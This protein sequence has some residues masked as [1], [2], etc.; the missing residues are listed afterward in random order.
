MPPDASTQLS[1]ALA[2]ACDDPL[3]A[4]EPYGED[5]GIVRVLTTEHAI[6]VLLIGHQ[7][8]VITVL[9]LNYTG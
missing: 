5:D 4:T 7:T 2:S 9:Q 1:Y 3:G 8:K 6:V